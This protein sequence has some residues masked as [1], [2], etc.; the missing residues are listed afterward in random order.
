MGEAGDVFQNISNSPIVSRSTV[1]NSFNKVKQDF[2]E[3]T[4]SA[5]VKIAEAVH[6]SGNVA[7]GSVFTQFNEEI[8]KPQSDKSK[9]RQYWDG[10]LAILPGIA[11]LTDA[12]AKVTSLFA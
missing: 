3:E 6:K 10:L 1:Q 7:A 11:Q 2:D 8:Q 12:V 5:I 4:A 9:L